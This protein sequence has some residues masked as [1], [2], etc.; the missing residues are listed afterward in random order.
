M[1]LWRPLFAP[2]ISP[3]WKHA[4]NALRSCLP[5]AS[6][7]PRSF[8]DS[9]CPAKLSAD[10][11]MRGRHMGR[12]GCA[13]LAVPVASRG[14]MPPRCAV[15]K[16]PSCAGQRSGDFQPT[17]GPC[18]E[19]SRSSGKSAMCAILSPKRGASCA[20]WDGVDNGQRGRRR[21]AIQPRLRIGS[22]PPGRG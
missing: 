16:R 9:A 5:K 6:G 7:K 14:S 1:P 12:Q 22:A 15:S 11:T 17:C 21:S 4:G 13:G 18:S 20:S 19:S 8:A 2:G 10:G 3:L